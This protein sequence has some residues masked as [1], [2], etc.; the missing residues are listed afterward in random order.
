M[1][2]T[3]VQEFKHAAIIALEAYRSDY[4]MIKPTHDVV[5]FQLEQTVKNCQSKEEILDALYK[6][7]CDVLKLKSIKLAQSLAFLI[8]KEL[9]IEENKIAEYHDMRARMDGFVDGSWSF[10][11]PNQKFS[12]KNDWTF[13]GDR[14]KWDRISGILKEYEILDQNTFP[15]PLSCRVEKFKINLSEDPKKVIDYDL[16]DPVITG[17]NNRELTKLNHKPTLF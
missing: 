12:R 14:S 13:P 6:S 9:D 4:L 16:C 17:F 8:G 3:S 15:G 2:F 7:Y 10:L 5:A 11:N 1:P